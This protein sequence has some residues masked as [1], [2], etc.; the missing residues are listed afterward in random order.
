MRTIALSVIGLL[1]AVAAL[2]PA[3]AAQA[4]SESPRTL[5]FF[6]SAEMFPQALFGFTLS[7]TG[8]VCTN[9]FTPTGYLIVMVH[10]PRG[11]LLLNQEFRAG[12][13]ADLGLPPGSY[14]LRVIRGFGLWNLSLNEST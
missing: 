13:C 7:G 9:L 6:N 10:N 2:A 5:R 11:D 4:E 3:R 1:L 8:Q 12:T 14:Q